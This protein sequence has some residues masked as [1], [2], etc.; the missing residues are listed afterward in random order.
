MS[1]NFGGSSYR[2]PACR[3]KDAFIMHTKNTWLGFV[4]LLKE[5]NLMPAIAFTFSRSSTET[6]A[7]NLSSVDLT[8]K[9]EKQQI[10]KFFSTITGRLRK[11]DRKLASVKFLHD[12]TRRGLAVHHSGMLPILKETVELLFRAGLVKI[13]FATETVS[14]GVNTPARCVVFTSLEKFDG[15]IRRSLDPSKYYSVIY[16]QGAFLS[17]IYMHNLW[18]N[19]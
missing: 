13:L 6:L 19:N 14:T 5:Q 9:S 16:S 12:L 15:H 17:I 3:G 18:D 7:K 11:C 4:N 2:T 10:T 1:K 8:C